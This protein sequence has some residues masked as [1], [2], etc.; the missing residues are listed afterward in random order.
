MWIKVSEGASMSACLSDLEPGG[1][2]AKV[3]VM[4]CADIVTRTAA[5]VAGAEHKDIAF[6]EDRKTG[7]GEKAEADGDG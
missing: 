5:Q 3:C 7:H 4:C 2:V 1:F 6:Q